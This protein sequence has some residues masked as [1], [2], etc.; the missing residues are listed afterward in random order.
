MNHSAILTA[1][2]VS[3]LSCDT[4]SDP[5]SV[6]YL[7]DERQF[8][9]QWVPL[10]ATFFNECPPAEEVALSGKAHFQ[11]RESG[12][13]SRLQINWADV[14]GTGL[15]SGDRYIVQ[16]VFR[17]EVITTTTGGTEELIEHIRMLRQ[18]SPS[19]LLGSAHVII[20][21]ASGEAVLV[22]IRATCRG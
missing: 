14:K 22:D 12:E 13:Q 10:N 1:A 18:G 9:N 7:R 8:L 20:D 11:F 3:L 21:L 2:L 16:D 17:D 4:S 19:N 5:A 6:V 15:V